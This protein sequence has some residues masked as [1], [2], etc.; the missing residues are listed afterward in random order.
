MKKLPVLL[1]VLGALC[2]GGALDVTCRAATLNIPGA[3]GTD[4]ALVVNAD[5]VI[6][7]SQAVDGAW[8]SDNTANAGKGVYDSS[9][10]AV[11]FKYSS[12]TV[13]PGATLTFKNHPSRAPVVWLVSGDVGIGGTVSLDGEAAVRSPRLAEPGPGGFRGGNGAYADGFGTGSGFG[14]GGGFKVDLG[15]YGKHVLPGNFAQPKVV[16]A[17]SGLGGSWYTSPIPVP[18]YGNPSLV[19]LLGGSG[20][21]GSPNPSGTPTSGGAGGGAIL[22]ATRG[23]LTMGGQL[24]AKGGHAGALDPYAGVVDAYGYHSAPGSGGGI[25]LVASQVEGTGLVSALGG[26]H[27]FGN[28]VGVILNAGYGRI[29]V[30]RVTNAGTVQFA[31]DP[32]VLTLA[33]GATPILWPPAGSPEVRV[34]SVGGVTAPADP[35]SGF[36]SAGPDVSLPLVSSTVVMVETKNV[37]TLSQVIVRLT[38]RSN[39]NHTEVA[40][41]L[42][43]GEGQAL[44]LWR[45]ELPVTPGYSAVQVR[46]IR[47]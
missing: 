42:E 39:T 20:G 36:G 14:S 34:V 10:W 32:S 38:P 26:P 7:L 2:G 16:Q 22:I 8:D 21:A 23:T 13:A 45:A 24:T 27:Y 19:P 44:R 5:T 17:S 35:R 37:E 47:P 25:R 31:P 46:V 6:D 9:K 40:A 12:V 28:S 15:G 33:D 11:V 3:N 4:G 30:E 41:A 29:R 1:T 18:T 43:P